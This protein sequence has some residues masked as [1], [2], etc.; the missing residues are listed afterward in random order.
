MDPDTCVCGAPGSLEE[1]FEE[2]EEYDLATAMEWP[3]AVEPV[4]HIYAHYIP[5]SPRPLSP[6]EFLTLKL[7]PIRASTHTALRLYHVRPR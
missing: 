6:F 2:L 4:P 1:L 3:A 5:G 7:S